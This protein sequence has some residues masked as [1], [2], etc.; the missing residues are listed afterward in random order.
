LITLGPDEAKKKIIGDNFFFSDLDEN[1]QLILNKYPDIKNKKMILL[2]EKIYD[3]SAILDKDRKFFKN[4][5]FSQ[6]SYFLFNKVVE[7]TILRWTICSFLLK[8]ISQNEIKTLIDAK[9]QIKLDDGFFRLFKKYIF[10][11]STFKKSDWIYYLR[12]CDLEEKNH[13]LNAMN[14]DEIRIK[15]DLGFSAKL[16]YTDILNDILLSSYYRFKDLLSD[17]NINLDNSKDAKGWAQ[18]VF[19]AGDRKEKFSKGD[20]ED[21]GKQIQMEFTFEN[22]NFPTFDEIN[23]EK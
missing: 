18:I 14:Q 1:F 3:L 7:N 10:N 19:E 9:Y 6:D 13:L 16:K 17:K 20:L 21:F 5:K 8:N 4:E 11:I 12:N 22:N 23:R 2:A 15:H